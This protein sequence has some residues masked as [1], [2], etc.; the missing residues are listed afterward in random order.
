VWRTGGLN[1]MNRLHLDQ[2]GGRD[3]PLEARI[4]S[5]EMA[6]RMQTEAQEVFDL[7]REPLAVRDMYGSGPF[8]DACLTPTRGTPGL[9]AVP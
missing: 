1:E 9:K 4:A 3:N 5:L 2:R 7:S 6:F 8:A